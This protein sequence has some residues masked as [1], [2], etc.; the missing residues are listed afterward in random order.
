M[1]N[2]LLFSTAL[3][4][5]SLSF[6]ANASAGTWLDDTM[7]NIGNFFSDGDAEAKANGM[8]LGENTHVTVSGGTQVTLNELSDIDFS[9][10]ENIA[11]KFSET[12]LTLN[13]SGN[14]PLTGAKLLTIDVPSE[15]EEGEPE[16]KYYI[17]TEEGEI[18][19]ATVD[20]EDEPTKVTAAASSLDAATITSAHQA[21]SKELGINVDSNNSKKISIAE[22]ASLT[23]SGS[24]VIPAED[25]DSEDTVQNSKI[26][27]EGG[28]TVKSGGTLLLVDKGELKSNVDNGGN[29]IMN[30]GKID[31]VLTL[32]VDSAAAEALAKE[33]YNND[34]P[35]LKS[36]NES[37][38]AEAVAN[39]VDTAVSGKV[40]EAN[41]ALGD[42]EFTAADLRASVIE[43]AAAD[44]IKDVRDAAAKEKIDALKAQYDNA[45]GDDLDAY[46]A[47]AKE[48]LPEINLDSANDAES[49]GTAIDTATESNPYDAINDIA[50]G[51]IDTAKATDIQAAK[52]EA[53]KDIVTE[54]N[55]KDGSLEE[56]DL[57]KLNPDL[58]AESVGVDE[59]KV[60]EL[61]KDY[62]E[63]QYTGDTKTKYEGAANQ[64]L[65]PGAVLDG[66]NEITGNT[67]VSGGNVVINSGKTTLSGT[68]NTFDAGS[69][70]SVKGTLAGEAVSLNASTAEVSGKV[71]N[72]VSLTKSILNL[73]GEMKGA[74]TTADAE[75]TVNVNS[76]TAKIAS[77][78]D[79]STTDNGILHIAANH[80]VSK[81]LGKA[82]S[83]KTL[84]VGEGIEFVLDNIPAVE[85]NPEQE[86]EAADA[87]NLAAADAKVDGTLTFV[88]DSGS[89]ISGDITVEKTG[90][91]NADLADVDN[92]IIITEAGAVLA[93][94]VTNTS[95]GEVDNG[96]FTNEASEI[97]EGTKVQ[98]TFEKGTD[99]SK[100]KEGKLDLGAAVKKALREGNAELAT[101]FAYKLSTDKDGNILASNASTAEKAS[102]LAAAGVS[103][104][105]AG[106]AAAWADVN[107]STPTG[108]ALAQAMYDNLQ[109]GNAAS[110]AR[111]AEDVAPSAAPVVQTVETGIMNQAYSAVS[112]QLSGGH[113]SSAAQG[114]SS[115]DGIFNKASAWVRT[116]FNKTE[117]DDTSKAKG[118]DVETTGVAFGFDKEVA[119]DVKAGIAYAY[120]DTEIDG[121]NRDTD[122]DSHTFMLY[123]EYKPSNWYVNGIASYSMSDYDEKKHSSVGNIDGS[124][125]VD[126]YGLQAMT[127]YE[128]NIGGYNLT[129]EAGLRYARIKQE[130]YTDSAGQR[131][132]S[133]D[134]DILTGIVGVKANKDFALENGMK[135]RPE[136]RLAM[137]YDLMDGENDAIVN[138]GG[139]SY[140]IDGENLD[141]FGI[142][143]GAGLTAE[144]NDN[145]DVSAGYEGKFR[146]DYTDH[147]GILSA[148]YKF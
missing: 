62:A 3:V 125:D 68:T 137:T 123:G 111:L 139:S 93:A 35:W 81:L 49:V 19:S 52:D 131:I 105:A 119:E 6:A 4:A 27:A 140:R 20:N 38:R 148:K 144:L 97:A 100:L 136:A 106:A 103:A 78:N 145:W 15:D 101:N 79:G 73:S 114:K 14:S 63:A 128:M 55:E 117:L 61:E 108:M 29:L 1:R 65:A 17:L 28:T 43:T 82:S 98:A 26:I 50:K 107:G 8:N 71:E 2:K 132:S 31:G 80:S 109:N 54:L 126:T 25:E 16:T 127:G 146:D 94:R 143:A 110:A 134:Q 58:I 67:S 18:F 121:H 85:A 86:I 47:A 23:I 91:V 21:L 104:N 46:K 12:E 45:E 112:S 116:L 70:L 118:F 64:T 51:E 90:T 74:L 59:E 39:A 33:N 75:S 89:K 120:G 56:A 115:G 60:A 87:I 141:R 44:G 7:A 66:E 77:L 129:P 122:V 142:E 72:D 48:L 95:D 41:E 88:K 40:T 30:G 36:W 10:F 102:M 83:V 130:A 53:A 5:A 99:L 124:Y 24:K 9:K 11:N 37:G 22:N 42:R 32:K 76:S 133:D 113:I 135:L 34:K 92:K 69:K 96:S 147:T 57:K 84:S 138:I 13:N